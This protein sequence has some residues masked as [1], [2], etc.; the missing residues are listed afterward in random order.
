MENESPIF[1]NAEGQPYSEQFDDIYHT[2]SRA[3][4]QTDHVFLKGCGL[5]QSWQ[6]KKQ[7]TILEMGFG[8][9]LN[10]LTTWLRWKQDPV[11]CKRLHF[12]SV[13]AYPVKV[14]DI[15]QA[16]RSFP[17]LEEVGREL[18]NAYPSLTNA[19]NTGI[20][21]VCFPDGD[22]VQVILSLALGDASIV[23]PQLEINA[24]AIY[25]DGFSP[26]KNPQ[27]WGQ[28]ICRELARVSR[29]GTRIATWCVASQVRQRLTEAGF[30]VQRVAG[31]APKRNSL[32]GKYRKTR[33]K[34][35]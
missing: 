20:Q 2:S 26:A 33:T 21:Q 18:I 27:L 5:P 4:K 17:E 9:G 30:S 34:M 13:E 25:L 24:D 23:L 8:L 28:D 31:L 16:L 7:F 14:D 35:N 32:T 6:H 3:V 1:W 12:V 22:G 11:R 19:V 10:F 15:E 29:P